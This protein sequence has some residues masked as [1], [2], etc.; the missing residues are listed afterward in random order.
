M[1]SIHS[2]I[3]FIAM[4]VYRVFRFEN[5]T[6]VKLVHFGL[7][8]GGM[9]TAGFGLKAVFDFHNTQNIPNMY[10][11]HSW[12]G[13]STVVLFACQVCEIKWRFW[14][15]KILFIQYMEMDNIHCIECL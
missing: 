5:K 14:L 9:I 1:S 15:Y 12:L 13:I 2:H 3:S 6:L 10:S 7:Q 11:L 4:I 8:F